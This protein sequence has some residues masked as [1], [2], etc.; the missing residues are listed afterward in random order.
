M[1]TLLSTCD[2]KFKNNW[3]FVISHCVHGKKLVAEVQEKSYNA[4]NH[5]PESVLNIIKGI[6]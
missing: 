6:K 1:T 4:I 2:C 5:I 3:P